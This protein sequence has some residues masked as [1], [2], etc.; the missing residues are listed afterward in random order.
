MDPATLRVKVPVLLGIVA[1]V[2]LGAVQG[3]R[4]DHMRDIER[5]YRWTVT[6]AS[7]ASFGESL[8]GDEAEDRADLLDDEIFASFVALGEESLPDLPVGPGDVDAEGD[9]HPRLVRAI[10]QDEDAAV[11]RLLAGDSG[12]PLVREFLQAAASDRLASIG[13]QFTA[14]SMYDPEGHTEGVGLTSLFFGLRKVAANFLW[15][16]VDSFWHSGQ[17]HRMVPAMRACVALDPNFIDAYLVGA[18]HLA[19]NLT[20][21]LPD[22]PEPQKE[23]H[24]RYKVRVGPKE[25]WY[26]VAA[27]FLKDGIKKNPRTYQLYFDL[28]YAIYE[29]KLYDHP[30]AVRY[31][32]EARRYKHDQWVPRMLYYAMWRNGQYDDAIEGWIDYLSRDPDNIT[33]QRLLQVNRER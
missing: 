13:T 33:A 1:L 25:E 16:Q 3:A 19:Y 14:A 2:A 30:N 18:W 20:A 31:L 15:L 27:D 11:Y 8:E 23:F 9:E 26:Y 12:R 10:R 17:M 4:I 5:A 21:R 32:T 22:T 29:N 28:G 7:F 6:A 24:P